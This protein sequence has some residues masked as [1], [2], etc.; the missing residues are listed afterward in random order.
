MNTYPS[1]SSIL[2]KYD[3]RGGQHDQHFLKDESTLDA[4]VKA[5]DLKKNETVLEIGPGI[6]NLTERMLD[7]TKEVIAVELDYSLVNVLQDRFKG[8]DNLK[9]IHGDILDIKLP[10]F[11]K[12]V[13]N[14]PYSISSEIT[15]KLFKHKFKLGVLMYQYEF[16]KRMIAKTNSKD[17][18]RLSVN[19]NYFADASI[20][21]K[22]PKGAFIP[23]PEVQSAIIKL[24]PRPAPYKIDNEE[25][26]L[27]FVR[28][29][30][31]QRRKK[32]R[33]AIILANHLLHIPNVKDVVNMLP[34]KFMNKRAE[35]LTPEELG[36]LSNQITSIKNQ[37]FSL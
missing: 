31:S 5:S 34:E 15:F 27:S 11:D 20:I 9:I 7:C 30:F 25:F 13:A 12:A 24:I 16:A 4:I 33:N 26:F 2:K 8:V 19:T 10:Q 36:V 37:R 29:V 3:I 18:S 17:Y 14:L 6:G 23:I 1:I 21:R 22:V 32:I 35:N 28:A